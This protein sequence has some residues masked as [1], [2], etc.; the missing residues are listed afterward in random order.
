MLC[1]GL[2]TLLSA[3]SYTNAS[4]TPP[5]PCALPQTVSYQN[6]VLPIL[7]EDCYSCHNAKDYQTL[8]SGTLNMEDFSQLH[9][10]TLTSNGHNNTSF[11]IG[12]IRHDPGFVAMPYGGGKLDDCEI[13]TIE[14]WVNAGAPQN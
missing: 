2:V 7:K 5:T 13:A 12:N 8:T 6:N 11:L 10:Y 3:C 9:E 14:A 4:D 1:I